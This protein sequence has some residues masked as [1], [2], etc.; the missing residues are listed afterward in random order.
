MIDSIFS[1][2]VQGI[3]RSLSRANKHVDV[4]V[5]PQ[6]TESYNEGDQVSAMIGLKQ[7]LRNV[8]AMRNVI[9][10]ADEMQGSLLDIIA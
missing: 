3:H 8:Q 9:E 5:S 4:I 1:T 7:E 10:A 2:S 6:T